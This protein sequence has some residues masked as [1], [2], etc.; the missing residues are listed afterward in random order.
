MYLYGVCVC[1]HVCFCAG[2]GSM[3]VLFSVVLGSIEVY[4]KLGAEKAPGNWVLRK[5]QEIGC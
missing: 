5:R 1:L 2:M 3:V 4:R